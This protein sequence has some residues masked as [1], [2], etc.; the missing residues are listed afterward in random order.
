MAWRF[1]QA[2]ERSEGRAIQKDVFVKQFFDARRSVISV[3]E[4]SAD[5]I[6]SLYMVVKNI[7]DD[8]PKEKVYNIT[9]VDMFD[10]YAPL[11][12]TESEL[13]RAI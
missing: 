6:Q 13:L 11:T 10:E 1:V 12:Y 8:I 4:K 5:S 3:F 2:R 9:S 7:E